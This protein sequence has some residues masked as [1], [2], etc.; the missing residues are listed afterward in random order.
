MEQYDPKTIEPKW[1]QYWLDHKSFAAGESGVREPKYILDM[2]PYPS[3]DGLHVGHVKIYTASDVVSRYL[4]MRGF[5]VLHPTGWDAFGLPTENTAIKKGIHPATLTA[6]N[7]ERFRG[8]MQ[9]MGFSYDWDRE[10]NTTDPNYYKWTQWIFIQLFKMGLAYEATIPINWCPSCKT[11][12]A[13]EEVV[14]GKCE[15]CG[16]EVEEKLLRHWMLKITQYADRLLEGL[17]GLEW[18]KHIKELQEHWIGRSEGVRIAFGLDGSEKSIEVF[19]T[20]PDTLYGVTYVVLAPDHP[21][22]QEMVS[23][24]QKGAVEEYVREAAKIGGKRAVDHDKE[25]TGVFLGAYASHPLT[26]EKVPVWV[27]DYVISGY[28]SGAVMAVPAHD[29]RDFVFAEKYGLPIKQVVVPEK[30]EVA[31]QLPYTDMEG[32]LVAS[33]VFSGQQA[34]KAQEAI[35]QKLQLVGKGGKAVQ[36][37][38]R[39]WVFSRQR[40][41]GEPIPL[42]H[43]EKC[44]VVPVPEDELPVKLPE[45]DKYEPTGTGESPLSEIEEWVNVKCPTCANMGKR[46]TNT[47][48]Q[49]AGSSWYW[50]RYTSPNYEK[51][52]ADAVSMKRWLPVDLYVGGAE[53]AVLH[54]LYARFWQK[55]LFDKQLV[56][57]EEPFERFA[58]VGLVL[59]E[60]NQKMSKSRGNVVNPDEVITEVGADALRVYEMFMGPFEAAVA[61]NTSGIKGSRRFLERVW[62]LVLGRMEGAKTDSEAAGVELKLQQTIRRV[63][64]GTEQLKFNTAIAAMMELLNVLEKEETLAR[65][66]LETLVLLLAP[67]APHMAEELWQRMGQ[68]DPIVSATWPSWKQ[69]VLDAAMVTIPVQVNGKRRGELVV[70]PGLSQSAAEEQ[71]KQVENVQRHLANTEVVKVVYVPDRLINFVVKG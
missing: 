19:T 4:R 36:Y 24:E 6:Q 71:A 10:V 2:F 18:P 43:C 30:S 62:A 20:R 26:G 27:A 68:A 67:Y 55:A 21:F 50:L 8:Q 64:E 69:G 59:G 34:K 41:W 53:H 15:R 37:A 5:E 31:V 46:E 65:E 25:K 23:E 35:M 66:T 56:P 29:E 17:G 9:R 22:V 42:I 33:D 1:Q 39:D 7:I 44:G 51:G 16:T 70:G 11:G 49:W 47:M 45:V 57:Q 60:D 61:W 48:P 63:T 12:L 52:L 13:N 28:G 58:A 14:D 54:L 38:L 40:Y 32:V 3:G